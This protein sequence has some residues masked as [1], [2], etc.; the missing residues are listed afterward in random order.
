VAKAGVVAYKGWL[1]RGA[2]II[3]ANTASTYETQLTR[4]D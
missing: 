3:Y 1:T 4:D 2:D